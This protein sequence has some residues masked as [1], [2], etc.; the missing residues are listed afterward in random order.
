ML[1]R[2]Q[3]ERPASPWHKVYGK[4]P[5]RA[6]RRQALKTT[7]YLSL[8]LLLRYTDWRG[9]QN[10]TR[11]IKVYHVTFLKVLQFRYYYLQVLDMK[12]EAQK[13]SIPGL[14]L[15]L[16]KLQGETQV[17]ISLITKQ[18]H[19]VSIHAQPER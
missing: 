16:G 9:S 15:G 2:G 7:D 17:H 10:Y 14:R 13:R 18:N 3:K 12:T 8:S 1:Y 19:L 4:C 5:A 6:W 11:N